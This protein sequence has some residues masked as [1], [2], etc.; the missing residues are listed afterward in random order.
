MVLGIVSLKALPKTPKQKLNI[1]RTTAENI[2]YSTTS[3][4]TNPS[5]VRILSLRQTITPTP[6]NLKLGIE[7]ETPE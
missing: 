6:H 1:T 3:Y 4:P 7:S 2:L 5:T